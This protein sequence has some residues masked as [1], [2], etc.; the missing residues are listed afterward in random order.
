MLTTPK[1]LVH[2]D[3]DFEVTGDSGRNFLDIEGGGDVQ[4]HVQSLMR[5]ACKTGEVDATE[6][7]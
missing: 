2:L 4:Q 5:S 6:S 3:G 7:K 1:V